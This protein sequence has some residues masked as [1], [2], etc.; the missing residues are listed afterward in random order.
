VQVLVELFMPYQ[1]QEIRI[2]PDEYPFGMAALRQRRQRDSAVTPPQTSSRTLRTRQ[3][4][5]T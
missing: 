2:E 1:R 3:S 4:S 5:A